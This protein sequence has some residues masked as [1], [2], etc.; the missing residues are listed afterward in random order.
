MAKKK[1]TKKTPSKKSS[2]QDGKI[3]IELRVEPEQH[4]AISEKAEQAGIS[5]NQLLVGMIEWANEYMHQGE[6]YRESGK[7]I[8]EVRAKQKCVFLGRPQKH[9]VYDVDTEDG[10]ET[11]RR[12]VEKGIIYGILDFSPSIARGGD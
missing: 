4:K 6:P 7:D 2:A 8:V 3:R 5:L 11:E 1:T 9:E 10:Y 12:L